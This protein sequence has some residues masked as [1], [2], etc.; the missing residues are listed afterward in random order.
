L[1]Q[2]AGGYDQEQLLANTEHFIN[3]WESFWTQ[4]FTQNKIKSMQKTAPTR[5]TERES[6]SLA[7]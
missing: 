7:M 6:A 5:V 4:D 2:G 3:L 1:A